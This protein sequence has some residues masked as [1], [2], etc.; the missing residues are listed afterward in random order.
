L[1]GE[2]NDLNPA[3][4]FVVANLQSRTVM[5]VDHENTVLPYR[6]TERNGKLYVGRAEQ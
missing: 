5:V 2:Q 4:G 1:N 3:I 6:V